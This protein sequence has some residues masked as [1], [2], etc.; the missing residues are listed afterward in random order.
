MTIL[1]SSHLLSELS[2][3]CTDYAI[4][5]G[6]RL[7][8][9]L[10][11]EELAI[12][13]ENHLSIRTDDINATAALLERKLDIRNY[14]VYRNEE[15][16]VFE[17]I[18]DLKTISQAITNEGLTILKFVCEGANLEEYYLSKVGGSHA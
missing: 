18:D 17:K 13:C 7:I 14:K 12:K 10:S 6:G 2:E 9:K 11:A 5:S 4:I 8:D 16:H 1:I 3:L 15:L